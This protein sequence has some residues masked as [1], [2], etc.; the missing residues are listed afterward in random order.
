MKILCLLLALTLNL[1]GTNSTN[2]YY[3]RVM[4][5]SV[6]LY[7]KPNEQSILFELPTSYFVK[8]IN[9]TGEYYKV[10]YADLSGYVKKDQVTPVVG[11]PDTPYLTKAV[12]WVFTSDGAYLRSSPNK[13]AKINS[14]LPVE[15]PIYYYGNI[16][17]DEAVTLRG[18]VWYF[19]KYTKDD[20]TYTGY[21]YAGLCDNLIN[22]EKNVQVL[23]TTGNPFSSDSQEFINYLNKDTKFQ[24]ILIFLVSMPALALIYLLFKPYKISQNKIG[25]KPKKVDYFEYDDKEI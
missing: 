2:E 22:N 3:A 9:Q 1:S 19:A 21:V 14:T 11:V 20:K 15:Q 24:I 7:S 4:T 8:L 5:S 10:E 23:E 12:F 16:I 25:K 13:D 18:K 6:Y 17:G